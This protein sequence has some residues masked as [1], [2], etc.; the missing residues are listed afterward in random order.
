[1]ETACRQKVIFFKVSDNQTKLWRIYT[2]IH[3]HFAKGEKVVVTLPNLEAEKYLDEAL[4]KI[5]SES[6]LPHTRASEPCEARVVVTRV[7]KNLNNAAVVWNLCPEISSL[8][9]QCGRV[10]EL[11]DETSK[12]K[13]EQSTIKIAA[14]KNLGLEPLLE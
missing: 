3:R 5:P 8:Y 4:W 7:Q 9:E 14:Y 6:F 12:E 10:Y 13:T 1:M 11:L 2:T